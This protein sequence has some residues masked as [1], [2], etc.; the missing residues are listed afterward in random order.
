MTSAFDSCVRFFKSS[1]ETAFSGM[2][3]PAPKDK[4]NIDTLCAKYDAIKPTEP[5]KLK[6]GT[7]VYALY[8]PRLQHKPEATNWVYPERANV[9]YTIP[10]LVVYSHGNADNL[11]SATATASF[12]RHYLCCDVVCYEYT[13]YGDESMVQNKKASEKLLYEDAEVV[14][15]FA[16]QVSRPNTPLV[17]IGWS[18]GGAMATH[19]A[20]T[21]G[22]RASGL[23][24]LS[25]FSSAFAT[26]TKLYSSIVSSLHLQWLDVFNVTE[27]LKK[28]AKYDCALLVMHGK[29]DDKV[30]FELGQQNYATFKDAYKLLHDGKE[31]IAEFKE[32]EKADH[33]SIFDSSPSGHG[34]EM[35]QNLV[36]FFHNHLNLRV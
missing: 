25:S 5:L 9:A 23:V 21:W 3:Y 24:L 15:A 18:L 16:V 22:D 7:E 19:V 36:N 2:L 30:P 31:P 11:V 28:L 34:K 17:S 10:P 35:T 14:A 6:D 8:L 33:T 32:L 12:L 27:D 26:N 1:V 20:S 4:F 13:G 29:L